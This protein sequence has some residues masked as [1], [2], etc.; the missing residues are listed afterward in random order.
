MQR[1]KTDD[2][3]NPLKIIVI[4]ASEGLPSSFFAF[5][6]GAIINL[7]ELEQEEEQG[8]YFRGE[9]SI[10][11]KLIRSQFDANYKWIGSINKYTPDIFEDCKYILIRLDSEALQAAN[12]LQAN[13]DTN[14]RA[15]AFGDAVDR[16]GTDLQ[17]IQ[18]W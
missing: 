6:R 3:P 1:A 10:D 8:P 12:I 13:I 16:L 5:E 7:D 11:A 14:N 17:R 15:N 4:Y 18:C 9:N 2:G